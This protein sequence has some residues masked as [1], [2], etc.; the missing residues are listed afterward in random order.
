M[1]GYRYGEKN[2]VGKI[3]KKSLLTIA[4]SDPCG[5]AGLQADLRTFRGLGFQAFSVATAVTAQNE[6]KF[7]SVNPV[8][9][10][11]LRDHLKSVGGCD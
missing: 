9:P 11:V 3:K 10:K 2:V 7:I 6:N 4:G 8:S 5:G 1:L